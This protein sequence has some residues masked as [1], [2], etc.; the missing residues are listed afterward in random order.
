MESPSPPCRRWTDAPSCCEPVS[1]AVGFVRRSP[2]GG[3]IS[4]PIVQV[5][6][7]RQYRDIGWL[8]REEAAH[9]GVQLPN[10]LRTARQIAGALP[11][12]NPTGL[13]F[14]VA[15]SVGQ[16]ALE[17]FAVR[18]MSFRWAD[19]GASED[20]AVMNGGQV[21]AMMDGVVAQGAEVSAAAAELSR[22]ARARHAAPPPPPI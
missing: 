8:W 7:V 11:W 16:G 19:G 2:H 18:Q 12:G 15:A 5:S 13:W 10:W 21:L 20:L 6:L 22:G 17:H 4:S 14:A 3:K 1:A 9:R